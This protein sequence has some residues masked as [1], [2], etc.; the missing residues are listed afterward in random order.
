MEIWVWASRRSDAQLGL[1][2]PLRGVLGSAVVHQSLR[3]SGGFT[4]VL[5][6]VSIDQTQARRRSAMLGSPKLFQNL[7]SKPV[8][9]KEPTQSKSM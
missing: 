1:M 2:Q 6:Q 7:A 3:S 8:G 9:L 5:Q 4:Q